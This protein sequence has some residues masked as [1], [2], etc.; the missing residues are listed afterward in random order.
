MMDAESANAVLQV[1][2]MR[3]REMPLSDAAETVK[4][5]MAD[6]NTKEKVLAWAAPNGDYTKLVIAALSTRLIS[7]PKEDT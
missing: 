4:H 3:L 6:P 2:G 5:E 1:V 7:P